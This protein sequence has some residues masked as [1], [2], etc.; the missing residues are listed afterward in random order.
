MKSCIVGLDCHLSFGVS[1]PLECCLPSLTISDQ[2]FKTQHQLPSKIHVFKTK[3]KLHHKMQQMIS[4]LHSHLGLMRPCFLKERKNNNEK[5]TKI[6]NHLTLDINVVNTMIH[7]YS[8]FLKNTKHQEKH[9]YTFDSRT[10]LTSS[11]AQTKDHKAKNT[12]KDYKRKEKNKQ[13]KNTHGKL[14]Y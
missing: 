14:L 12:F 5:I 11:F 3:N 8:Y 7:N 10:C 1:S 4:T 9:A 2:T 13:Q 6:N